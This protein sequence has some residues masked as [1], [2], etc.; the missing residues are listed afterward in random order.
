[1]QDKTDIGFVDSHSKGDGR[2]H[3][4]NI[5][6]DKSFLVLSTLVIRQ[7]SVVW[8]YG[9]ACFCQRCGEIIHLFARQAVDDSRLIRKL[10]DK[11]NGLQN[12]TCLLND[13]Q[14]EIL[15]VETCNKCIGGFKIKASLNVLLDPWR[16]GCG[17]RHTDGLWKLF[18][19]FDQLTVLRPEIMSPFGYAVRFVNGDA[20]HAS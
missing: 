19:Y 15:P 9:K 14:K 10:F 12:R 17:Q 18:F 13:L 8:F 6:A 16:C 4:L 11:F 7:P 2:S 1:M 20:V 3:D 5:I